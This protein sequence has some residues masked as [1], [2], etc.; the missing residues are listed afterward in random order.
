MANKPEKAEVK[1][2]IVSRRFVVR[3]LTTVTV[4]FLLYLAALYRTNADP[5]RLMQGLGI[6][7]DMIFIDLLP[8]DWRY[9]STSFE[10]LVET[11]NIALLSTTFAA[12]IALPL[13]FLASHNIN[14]N[15]FLY[16]FIRTILNFLRTIPDIILAIIVVAFIGMGAVSGIV[17]L[18]VFTSGILA[19]MLSETTEGISQGPLDAIMASGGNKLQIIRYGVMPQILPYYA[20]YTLYVLEINVKA[21]VV[22]GFIGAGGIGQLLN[23]NMKFFRYDRLS[24]ILIVLFLTITLIDLVSNRVRGYLE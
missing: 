10:Y 5:I 23:R 19:K 1:I 2:H 11:W 8:P 17:A 20:S 16:R 4:F 3:M 6:I 9:F 14:K 12:V 18:T 24:M 21:S 15:P 22:L 13:T 7:W